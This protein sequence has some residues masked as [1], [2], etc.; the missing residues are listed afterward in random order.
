MDVALI[1]LKKKA[2]SVAPPHEPASVIN[3]TEPEPA[4]PAV[5]P[6]ASAFQVIPSELAICVA[7]AGGNLPAGTL[8]YR[9]TGLWRVRKKKLSRQEREWLAMSR[10]GWAKSAG[11]TIGQLKNAALPKLKKHCTAFIN[12]RPMKLAFDKPKQ[13]WI[14]LD[15]AAFE[16]AK[17][18]LEQ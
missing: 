12:I 8:L 2:P 3:C 10:D 9:I 16:E 17:A 11:L 13:L 5:Q 4:S 6:K 1:K 18:A 7:L 15:T 14:S